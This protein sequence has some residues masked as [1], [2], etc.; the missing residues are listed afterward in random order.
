M[1]LL[2]TYKLLNNN[3]RQDF[4][5]EFYGPLPLNQS[6]SRPRRERSQISSLSTR[7]GDD[8]LLRARVQTSRA[9]GNKLVFLNLRQ[10]THSVQAVLAVA[11]EK[12]SKQMVKW[13]ASLAD[14]SIVLVEGL[15]KKSPIPIQG[16]SVGDVEVHVKQ[17]GVAYRHFR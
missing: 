4:A 7:D 10:R 16:A 3:P 5:V 13:A 15:V 11:E 1:L 17:V 8:V 14:E 12:V 9:Q 6:Q 2:I